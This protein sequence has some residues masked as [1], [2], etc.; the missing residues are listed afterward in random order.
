MSFKSAAAATFSFFLVFVLAGVALTLMSGGG[1]S[2]YKGETLN[3]DARVVAIRA[4]AL[5]GQGGSSS[6]PTELWDEAG[7]IAKADAPKVMTTLRELA[8]S[9][10]DSEF[11]QAV[12]L[13]QNKE[14]GSVMLENA[15][16]S[17][18]DGLYLADVRPLILGKED[19][20]GPVR[21]TIER[22]TANE[23][24]LF[25]PVGQETSEQP[26]VEAGFSGPLVVEDGGGALMLVQSDTPEQSTWVA[27]ALFA[28][29][30]LVR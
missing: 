6:I 15:R 1:F 2:R 30:Q 14:S 9:T 7:A 29:A 4:M 5:R 18:A 16:T 23:N 21:L 19:E 28:D 20:T 8:T 26:L 24:V 25:V 13:V 27:I 11:F 22:F 3:K 17:S 10:P 12:V